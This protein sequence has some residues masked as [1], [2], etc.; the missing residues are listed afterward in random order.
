MGSSDRAQRIHDRQTHGFLTDSM[1]F[2]IHRQEI[3]FI[4]TATIR[5]GSGIQG[6]CWSWTKRYWLIRNIGATVYMPAWGTSSKIRILGWYSSF[7]DTTVGLYVNGQAHSH[8]VLKI[9]GKLKAHLEQFVPPC[10]TAVERWVIVTIDEAYIHCSKHVPRLAKMDKSIQ[11]GPMTRLP[12]PE[13]FL[14]NHQVKY[15]RMIRCR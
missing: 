5:P 9:P 4:A 10:V 12:S 11:W 13:N 7:F 3:V 15:D 1:I 6:L 14:S 8:P 2:L